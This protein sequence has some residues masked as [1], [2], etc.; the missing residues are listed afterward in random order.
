MLPVESAA[1]VDM[2]RQRNA[3]QADVYVKFFWWQ[4]LFPGATITLAI[5]DFRSL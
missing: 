4:N 1:S 5:I 3:I 2:V